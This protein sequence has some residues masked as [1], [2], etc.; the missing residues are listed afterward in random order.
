MFFLSVATT[1]ELWIL[2]CNYVC[3]QYLFYIFPFFNNH[4]A[5]STS[6]S[7]EKLSSV[8]FAIF[9]VKLCL[10]VMQPTIKWCAFYS[11]CCVSYVFY[12]HGGW[13]A[14]GLL[15]IRVLICYLL[16]G[17]LNL[18]THPIIQLYILISYTLMTS[19][20]E[21]WY[22]HEGLLTYVLFLSVVCSTN[23]V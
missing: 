17:C 14:R 11:S 13:L 23:M 7:L 2:V 22:E 4:H 5:K 10:R 21:I 12:H 9:S 1:A 6:S 3:N 18:S 8:Y 20:H 16:P 15:S 19:F